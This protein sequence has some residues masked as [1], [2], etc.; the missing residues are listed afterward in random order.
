M[1]LEVNVKDESVWL[2]QAQMTQLFEVGRTS[3]TRHINNIIKDGEVDE[4]SNVQF[5]HIANSDRPVQ[6]YNLDVII[7]VGYRVKSKRGIQFRKWATRK[8]EDYIISSYVKINGN[9]SFIYSFCSFSNKSTNA[10]TSFN[11]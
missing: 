3:I 1:Q 8:L 5:L 2:T 4:K 9:T 7:S 10:S 6:A 11:A